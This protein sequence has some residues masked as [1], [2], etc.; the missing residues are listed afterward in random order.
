MPDPRPPKLTRRQIDVLTFVLRFIED[1]GFPP[2]IREI[3]NH[4]GVSSTNGV[5]H[6]VKALIEKRYL[7]RAMGTSRGLL[8]LRDVEGT[9]LRA[10]GAASHEV[11]NDRPVEGAGIRTAD[12]LLELASVRTERDV[13]AVQVYA[14]TAEKGALESRIEAMDAEL[15]VYAERLVEEQTLVQELRALLDATGG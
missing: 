3:M 6:H 13:L 1:E 10:E 12:V 2:T 11:C 7:R 14:L 8:V 5:H 9:T 4:L 15:G